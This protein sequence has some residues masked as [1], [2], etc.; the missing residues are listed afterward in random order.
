MRKHIKKNHKTLIITILTTINLETIPI[1]LFLKS[2]HRQRE[3]TF[4]LKLWHPWSIKTFLQKKV[5]Y[6]HRDG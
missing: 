6:L 5:V 3:Y 2:I 4:F 1:H